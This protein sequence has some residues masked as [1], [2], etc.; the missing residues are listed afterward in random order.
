MAK[1]IEI[2]GLPPAFPQRDSWHSEVVAWIRHILFQHRADLQ[3]DT[4]LYISIPQIWRGSGYCLHTI[5]QRDL[6][7]VFSERKDARIISNV[8]FREKERALLEL[9]QE[10]IAQRQV[11]S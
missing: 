4:A 8:I 5:P 9:E 6:K 11:R 2:Q 10:I 1:V 7:R 3:W